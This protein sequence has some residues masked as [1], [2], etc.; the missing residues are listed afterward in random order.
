M[1]STVEYK[2]LK[3]N[4]T[5]NWKTGQWKLLMLNGKRMK[6]NENRLRDLWDIKF[7][8]ICILEGP[9]EERGKGPEKTFEN[10]IGENFPY[11]GR[12]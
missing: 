4:G 2:S 8:N 7:T 6:R 5:A 12:K 9:G 11:L 1:A 3:R 10:K